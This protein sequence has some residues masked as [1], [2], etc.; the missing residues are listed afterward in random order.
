[1]Q[2]IQARLFD[3]YQ[4]TYQCISLNLNRSTI[5]FSFNQNSD[6]KNVIGNIKLGKMKNMT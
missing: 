2:K 4:N 3:S 6:D 1:M 5:Y